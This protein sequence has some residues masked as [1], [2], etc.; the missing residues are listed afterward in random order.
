MSRF[1]YN[2]LKSFE[3]SYLDEPQLKNHYSSLLESCCKDKKVLKDY[4]AIAVKDSRSARYSLNEIISLD[5][6]PA[7]KYLAWSRIDGSLSV[8]RPPI[9]ADRTQDYVLV[10]SVK[11]DVHGEGKI[12]Y[13]IS[14]NPNELQFATVGNTPT[15]KIWNVV[16]NTLRVLKEFKTNFKAKNFINEYDPLGKFLA[17]VTKANELY[18]FDVESGYES[19]VSY[20]PENELDDEIHSMCWSNDSKSIILAYRSGFI[21]GLSVASNALEM[22]WERRNNM[23]TIS[24]L[25]MDPLGRSVLVGTHNDCCIWSLPDLIPLKQSIKTENRI[26]GIDISFDGSIIAIVSKAKDSNDAFLNLYWYNDLSPLYNAVVKNSSQSSIKWSR[27]CLTFFTTGALDKMTLVDLRSSR[28]KTSFPHD[29]PKRSEVPKK[30]PERTNRS[31]R[32]SKSRSNKDKDSRQQSHRRD[33]DKF[34]DRSFDRPSSG[35]KF[36][37]S[38]DRW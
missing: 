19:F 29:D 18:V 21:R 26:T 23:K 6:H 3:V 32:D 13:S 4:H 24:F 14:W 28:S 20:C 8:M 33:T 1:G 9:S 16:D 27:S 15:V 11:K 12:V 2:G 10:G 30:N 17:V 37:K 38:N 5:S 25:T 7:A 22:K 36:R 35:S 34:S 31:L